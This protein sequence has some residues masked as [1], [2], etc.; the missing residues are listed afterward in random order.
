MNT[1]QHDPMTTRRQLKP[2]LYARGGS[3]AVNRCRSQLPPRKSPCQI[4]R[5]SYDMSSSRGIQA[6]N[7]PSQLTV[8]LMGA[9]R[10][11]KS[12]LVNQ[13]LW[14]AFIREYRPTVEEFNWIEYEAE[15]GELLVQIIDSSGSRDFL[16]M[17]DL[18]YKQG[19]AFMVVYA[20]DDPGSYLEAVQ[21]VN[22]IKEKSP[23]NA[24]VLLVGNKADLRVPDANGNV[25]PADA[26]PQEFARRNQIPMLNI[27]A[28]Q[29]KEVQHVFWTLMD[30]LRITCTP[31]E[32]QLKKRRQSMPSRR[33]A[34]DLGIDSAALEQLVKKHDKKQRANCIIM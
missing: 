28:K 33:T 27:T 5:N 31:S 6:T 20:V 2:G 9:P 26:N 34:S 18:Y 23:K 25:W 3:H 21:I 32:L 7:L 24:P 29:L 13:F 22:E 14:E 8:V 19:D 4:P 11:G 16:A 1:Y 17:R 30:K 15:D 12:T 10:V